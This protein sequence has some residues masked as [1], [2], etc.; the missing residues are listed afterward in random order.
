M[1]SNDNYQYLITSNKKKMKRKNF[2]HQSFSVHFSE[3]HSQVTRSKPYRFITFDLQYGE[4]NVFIN[5]SMIKCS[6]HNTGLS[7]FFPPVFVHT[8]FAEEELR[9]KTYMR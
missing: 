4:Q 5:L 8:S 7:S 6:R 2:R 3:V 9:G 1:K